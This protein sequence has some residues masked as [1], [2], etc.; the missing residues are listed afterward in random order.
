MPDT[1]H[2]GKAVEWFFKNSVRLEVR[3][4]CY[5]SEPMKMNTTTEGWNGSHSVN[6]RMCNHLR[7]GATFVVEISGWEMNA[8]K[9]MQQRKQGILE[10]AVHTCVRW[11]LQSM[12]VNGSSL[13]MENGTGVM[14]VGAIL[15]CM[16][17]K[18]QLD[19]LVEFLKAQYRLMTKND[20]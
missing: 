8:I 3:Q 4:R 6:C 1:D 2:E 15:Q 7:C 10:S 13:F 16:E 19:S 14:Q 18:D 12:W 9:T 17:R 20:G 5:Y 11:R